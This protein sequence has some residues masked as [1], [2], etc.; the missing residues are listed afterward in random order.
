MHACPLT[1]VTATRTSCITYKHAITTCLPAHM[2]SSYTY[3]A[4][5]SNLSLH[6][7]QSPPDVCGLSVSNSHQISTP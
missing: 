5:N 2:A 4:C 1:T 6:A 7:Q 3:H